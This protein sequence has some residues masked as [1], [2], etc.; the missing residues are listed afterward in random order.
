MTATIKPIAL[1]AMAITLGQT[2]TATSSQTSTGT[3]TCT[4]KASSPAVALM[5][6]PSQTDEKTWIEAAKAACE[7][8]KARNVWIW[9]DLSKMPASAPQTDAELPKSATSAAVAVWVND[10]SSLMKLKK[11]R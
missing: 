4:V 1:L 11:A 3:S 9:D 10:S 5:Y 2:T 8:G 7:P 6:C